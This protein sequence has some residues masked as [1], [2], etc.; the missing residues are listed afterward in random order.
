MTKRRTN[1]A[2]ETTQ[3][4]GYLREHP[5][6]TTLADSIAELIALRRASAARRAARARLIPIVVDV[7]H[8]SRVAS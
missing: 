5:A 6:G 1:Q 2:E 7:D 4:I 8:R 3:F